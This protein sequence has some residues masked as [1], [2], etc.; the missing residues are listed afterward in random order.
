MNANYYK[1]TKDFL[2]HEGQIPDANILTYIQ[3]L[4]EVIE[5]MRPKTQVESRRLSMAKQ[6][7]KDVECKNKSMFSK[8]G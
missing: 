5:N 3:A 8:K 6:Q 2:L 7:L 1:M 4:T